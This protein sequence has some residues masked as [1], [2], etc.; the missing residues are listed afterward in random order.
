M[1]SRERIR[2][3]IAGEPTDRCGFWLGSPGGRS[4]PAIHKHFGTVENEELRQKVGDDF[5]WIPAGF[6]N[7]PID[8]TSHGEAGPFAGTVIASL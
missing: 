7:F 1:T 4:W 6:G 5:R 8:K 3:I 2:A